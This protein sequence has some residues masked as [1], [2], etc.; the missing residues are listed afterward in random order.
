M[1]I[2][3]NIYLSSFH[4][5]AN[6]NE[7]AVKMGMQLYF[8]GAD[9][10]SFSY[11]L[12]NDTAELH[13]VVFLIWESSILFSIPPTAYKVLFSNHTCEQFLTII[14]LLGVKL[15]S[16]WFWF[17]YSPDHMD[18]GHVFMYLLEISMFSSEKCLLR[19]S[20]SFLN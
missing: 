15:E 18:V 9:S 5:L 10:I 19:F 11:I 1:N 3:I 2:C 6:M 4:D 12:R 7:F 17:A 8:W 14:F 13:V 20:C 16:L